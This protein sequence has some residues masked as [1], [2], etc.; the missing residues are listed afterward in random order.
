ML[1]ELRASCLLGSTKPLC[2]R[3][4]RGSHRWNGVGRTFPLWLLRLML[5]FFF[6]FDHHPEWG[7]YLLRLYIIWVSDPCLLHVLKR[8]LTL[9]IQTFLHPCQSVGFFSSFS[10]NCVLSLSRCNKSPP[11]ILAYTHKSYRGRTAFS[12]LPIHREHLHMYYV[13]QMG[14]R[15]VGHRRIVL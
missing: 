6:S 8:P 14:P 3:M 1:F 12:P 4:A 10:S 9:H 15:S 11:Q 7:T 5:I 13:V 2:T